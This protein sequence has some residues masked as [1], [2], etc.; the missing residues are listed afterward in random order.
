MKNMYPKWIILSIVLTA[1]SGPVVAQFSVSGEFRM[2]PEYRDGYATLRDSSKT[3]YGIILGRA[4]AIFDFKTDKIMTR[5]SLQDAFVFGQNNYASDTISK[6][7]V[8][9]FEAWFRY[10]FT[11]KFALKIGRTEVVYDDERFLG[12]SD[13]AMWGATHDIIIAQWG[14]PKKNY[15]GDLGIAINNVA[16]ANP[17]VPYLASYPLKNYKYMAYTWE[18][19]K[20]MEDKLSFSFLALADGFQAPSTTVTKTTT[21]TLKIR[22]SFDSIIGTTVTK[23]TTKVT[24]DYPNQVYL[25]A[26]AGLDGWLTLKKWSF[27]LSGYY[28]GGHYK[29]GKTINAW[30]YS[31]NISWKVIKPLKLMV[32]YDH[33]D[34]NDFSDTTAWK[35]KMTGFSTL[36]GTAHRLYGYMDMWNS[37]VRDNNTA[38]LNDLYLRATLNFSEKTFIE[39]TFRWFSLARGFLNKKDAVTKLPYTAVDKNLGQEIDLMFVY[40]PIPNLDLNAAYCFFLPTKTME[41]QRDIQEGKSKFA[42]YAYIMVTY[43]P[44]FFTSEKK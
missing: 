35:T 5:F 39:G 30:F 10:S 28:Q 6:N 17:T 24:T 11:E 15:N 44:N 12:R 41:L 36:Y 23:N 37:Y 42:Q 31:A 18:H 33:L 1:L 4:R 40:K 19:F 9:M 16:P 22:N 7:T 38:G 20:L 32:G 43:K 25:R 21:D 26:T 29:D 2:R 8:N 13:W 27:S 14:D 3:P 34:G